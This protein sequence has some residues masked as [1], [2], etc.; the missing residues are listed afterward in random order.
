MAREHRAARANDEHFRGIFF[1]Q[2]GRARRGAR[3]VGKKA[4]KDA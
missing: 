2:D 4:R 3:V 1:R